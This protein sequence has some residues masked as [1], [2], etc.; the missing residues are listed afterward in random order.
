MCSRIDLT[1]GWAAKSSKVPVFSVPSVVVLPGLFSSFLGV[2]A[3]RPTKRV[4]VERK[5]HTGLSEQSVSTRERS[6]RAPVEKWVGWS[7]E[8][9][10]RIRRFGHPRKWRYVHVKTAHPSSALEIAFFRHQD[11]WWCVF[12]PD[13]KRPTMSAGQPAAS[14][15]ELMFAGVQEVA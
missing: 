7:S 10:T 8:R 6:L 3:V 15:G 12:P 5:G 1:P 9:K 4:R 11:G 13:V 14:D 2:A